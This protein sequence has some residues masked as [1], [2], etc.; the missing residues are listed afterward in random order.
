MP[1]IQPLEI[2]LGSPNPLFT[3]FYRNVQRPNRFEDLQDPLLDDFLAF[4]TKYYRNHEIVGATE[5]DFFANL[6]IAWHFQRAKFVKYSRIVEGV[7]P[8]WGTKETTILNTTND[9]DSS[10]SAKNSEIAIS[11]SSEPINDV[12][13]STNFSKNNYKNRIINNGHR[14]VNDGNVD[15]L[16]NFLKKQKT[17]ETYLVDIFDGCFVK[18]E[19]Y[20]Y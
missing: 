7:T 9:G 11:T 2:A 10:T 19:I 5:A 4:L 3:I 6:E 17:L 1:N 13:T 12:P 15:E 20:A 18:G 8:E 16:N 14:L